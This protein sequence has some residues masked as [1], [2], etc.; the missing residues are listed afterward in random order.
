MP[1]TPPVAAIP[2]RCSSLR[3][4][5]WSRSARAHECVA[6][7]TPFASSSTWSTD[8][9]ARCETSRRI[10]SRSSSATARTPEAGR[11]LPVASSA[12]PSASSA[13]DQCVNETIRT[14]SRWK[15]ENSSTSAPIPGVPSSATSSAIFLSASAASISAAGAAER[16]LGRLRRLALER[17]ELQQRRASDASATSGAT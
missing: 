10:P 15:T 8:G 5:W 3:L 1:I 9:A 7:T 4:R 14:P 12:E 13:R 17:L 11:R 2:R 16:D 6:T